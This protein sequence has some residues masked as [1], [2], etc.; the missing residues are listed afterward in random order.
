MG[1]VWRVIMWKMERFVYWT[2][3]GGER[4]GRGNHDLPRIQPRAVVE[5]QDLVAAFPAPPVD[6]RGR[7]QRRGCA[8]L[9]WNGDKK[10]YGLSMPR[11]ALLSLHRHCRDGQRTRCGVREFSS[12]AIHIHPN[13][14]LCA[15]GQ[16]MEPAACAGTSHAEHRRMGSDIGGY[17]PA[18]SDETRVIA[19]KAA[20][21]FAKTAIPRDAVAV[22]QP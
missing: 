17:G 15:V 19:C 2:T 6:C 9:S 11:L 3:R 10:R 22:A 20:E 21:L 16:G 12:P 18:L 13:G 14:A 8:G 1:T 5:C 7:A 4:K